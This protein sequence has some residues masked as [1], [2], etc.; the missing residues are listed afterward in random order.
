M[1]A[2]LRELAS[3][4]VQ[5]FQ[6]WHDFRLSHEYHLLFYNAEVQI[7]FYN[8]GLDALVQINSRLLTHVSQIKATV[9][10]RGETGAGEDR[11]AMSMTATRI[12]RQI[13][14]WNDNCLDILRTGYLK[15]N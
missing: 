14:S 8:Q 10:R 12:W 13:F 2:H 7:L 11:K 5:F 4:E 1:A 9:T 15:Q 3:F 6:L